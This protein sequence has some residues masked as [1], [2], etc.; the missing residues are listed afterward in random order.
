VGREGG[1]ERLLEWCEMLLRYRKITY[2]HHRISLADRHGTPIPVARQGNCGFERHTCRAKRACLFPFRKSQLAVCL[3]AG[4]ARPCPTSHHKQFTTQPAPAIPHPQYPP[5]APPLSLRPPPCDTP[6][7]P[8][9][10]PPPHH[11]VRARSSQT[12]TSAPWQLLT[13]D[14]AIIT[15]GQATT[16]HDLAGFMTRAVCRANCQGDGCTRTATQNFP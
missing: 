11:R 6:P 15:T 13:D 14:P 16:R 9:L 8:Q 4:Q 7:P 12:E 1:E 3:S 5:S 2:N 10:R